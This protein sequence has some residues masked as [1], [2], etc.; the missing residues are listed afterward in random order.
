[1]FLVFLYVKLNKITIFLSDCL[2]NDIFE[3]YFRILWVRKF[4]S[5]WL[6][7]DF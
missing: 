3:I 1:M 5:I 7:F 4:G 2:V 6:N